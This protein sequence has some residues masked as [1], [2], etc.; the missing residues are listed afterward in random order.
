MK[1]GQKRRIWTKEQKLEI[2]G[3]HINEHISVRTLEK[4]YNADRSMICHSLRDYGK[5]GEVAFNSK[6]H[7]GNPF[8]ALHTSKTLTETERLRLQ[9][10]MWAEEK[11]SSR[12]MPAIS[13]FQM[14]WILSRWLRQ[15]PALRVRIWKTF[16]M[17]LQLTLQWITDR[18]LS[19]RISTRRLF[20]L[21]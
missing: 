14:M 5:Y 1:K 8:A 21:V 3:R 6:G 11:K 16:R 17:N 19:R 12:F 4:E 18:L 13:L 15:Q 9:D 10:L 20:R 2:I 7:P